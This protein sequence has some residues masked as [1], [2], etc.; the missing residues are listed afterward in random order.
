MKATWKD[1]AGKSDLVLVFGHISAEVIHL[2]PPL[3]GNA[4]PV[5]PTD[6]ADQT[7][8]ARSHWGII[9]H[10]FVPLELDGTRDDAKTMAEETLRDLLSKA[11]AALG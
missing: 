9:I 10:P 8:P 7:S 11:T 2:G 5:P 3:D 1:F 6:I 4:G